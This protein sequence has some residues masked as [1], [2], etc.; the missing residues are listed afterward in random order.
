[1]MFVA[2]L[3]TLHEPALIGLAS[4]GDGVRVDFVM[5]GCSNYDLESV[6]ESCKGG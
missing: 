3:E 5:N 6:Q 2:T 1:M 4:L